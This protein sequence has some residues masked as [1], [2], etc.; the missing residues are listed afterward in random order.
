[1]C[2]GKSQAVFKGTVCLKIGNSKE[3][4]DLTVWRGKGENVSSD[5]SDNCSLC[6]LQ[7]VGYSEI[8]INH[9]NSLSCT[10]KMTLF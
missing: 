7:K 2:L 10:F 3:K 8:D 6:A 9:E 1:M 4:L 5:L